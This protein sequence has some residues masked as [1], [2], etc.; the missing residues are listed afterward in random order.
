MPAPWSPDGVFFCAK[1]YEATDGTPPDQIAELCWKIVEQRDK[2]TYGRTGGLDGLA[3]GD[4]KAPFFPRAGQ[5]RT[6]ET[7]AAFAR[8]MLAYAKGSDS[9]LLTMQRGGGYEEGHKTPFFAFAAPGGPNMDDFA[10]IAGKVQG[11]QLLPLGAGALGEWKVVAVLPNSAT[12][13]SI[14]SD[15]ERGAKPVALGP[16]VSTVRPGSARL[17]PGGERRPT[18][19]LVEVSP[20][21]SVLMSAGKETTSRTYADVPPLNQASFLNTGSQPARPAEPLLLDGALLDLLA[22]ASVG[23]KLPRDAMVHIVVRRW[24][25]ENA[26]P[27][28]ITDGTGG[29]VPFASPAAARDSS[30]FFARGKRRPTAEEAEQLVGPF[31]AWAKEHAQPV[32]LTVITPGRFSI[33]KDAKALSWSGFACF[34]NSGGTLVDN[35][36]LEASMQVRGGCRV[37]T[38]VI[39]D[40]VGFSDPMVDYVHIGHGLATPSM[41]FVGGSKVLIADAT[42]QIRGVTLTAERPDRTAQ[43]PA[44]TGRPNRYVLFDARLVGTQW[45]EPDGRIVGTVAADQEMATAGATTGAH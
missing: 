1:A 35:P 21:A 37:M 18:T 15:A 19:L 16:I 34:G 42:L 39:N 43:Q 17:V 45:R 32:P 13:Y 5:E 12:L 33:P 36:Q 9:G 25:S 6:T 3:P 29:S 41:P 38:G 10:R 2:D 7:Q 4:A 27:L 30:R 11:N 14:P 24:L 26:P 40:G 22:A 28:T 44:E 23:D 8:W 20:I 31:L